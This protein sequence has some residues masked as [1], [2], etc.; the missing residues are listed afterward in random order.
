M[1][2]N[3]NK[4]EKVRGH[5]KGATIARC[6]A[7]AEEGNDRIGE[8]LIIYRDG[9]FGCVANAKDGQHNQRIFALAGEN[10]VNS[11]HREIDVRLFTAKESEVIL[12]LGEFPRFRSG[13]RTQQAGSNN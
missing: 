2:L 9:R 12:H 4:L 11:D 13:P 1:A 7:C 6:P 8:H 5:S 10:A 3:L